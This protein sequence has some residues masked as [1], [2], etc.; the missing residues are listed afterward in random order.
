MN[1][2]VAEKDQIMRLM[3]MHIDEVRPGY[4]KVSMP[5]LDSVKNGMGFAHGGT[6]FSLADIAFG[7]AAN[8]GA[9]YF[10]VT[11]NTSID[12]L[13]PGGKG[14]LVAE[15]TLVSSGKHI[16]CYNVAVYDGDGTLI[17]RTMTQ[18]Y[19]TKLKCR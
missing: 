10:V 17:A 1:N 13:K 9:E 4:A 8:E 11:L 2:T 3:H 15:A 7:A 6:I 12:F 5:L 18:G 14:P 16:Q 19:T